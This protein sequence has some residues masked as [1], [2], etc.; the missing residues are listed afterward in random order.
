MELLVL[1][2]G[3]VLRLADDVKESYLR[4][5]YD[6]TELSR[7]TAWDW[8]VNLDLPLNPGKRCHPSIEKPPIAPLT[9]TEGTSVEMIESVKGLGMFFDSSFKPSLQYKERY[10][11]AQITFSMIRRGFAALTPAIFRP[12]Y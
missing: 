11:R 3:K 12:R 6:N 10:A 5:Q 8:S 4:S 7:R 9:F 1:L 2:E